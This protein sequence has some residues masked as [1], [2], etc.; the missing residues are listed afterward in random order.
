ML[1]SGNANNGL[2]TGTFYLNTN[3]TTSNSNDNVGTRTYQLKQQIL[4]DLLPYLLVK[5]TA[6]LYYVLVP[7]GKIQG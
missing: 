1:S 3:W 2:N 7:N 6:M 4:N 5:H